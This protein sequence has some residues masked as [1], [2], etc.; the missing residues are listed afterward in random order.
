MENPQPFTVSRNLIFKTLIFTAKSGWPVWVIFIIGV[1]ISVLG[2][3]FDLRFLFVGLIVIFTM[4]PTTAFF[5]FTKYMFDSEMVANLL[6]HTVEKRPNGYLIHIF[7]PRDISDKCPEDVM[8][9]ESGRLTIF[10]S[11]VVKS[12]IMNGYEVLYLKDAPLSILFIPR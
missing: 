12:R 3:F 1:L 9:V 8:W 11:S 6:N 7:R 4:L 2:Y 10:D 5:I